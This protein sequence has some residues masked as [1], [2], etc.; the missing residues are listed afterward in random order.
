MNE[1]ASR[2]ERLDRLDREI[3]R[4]THELAKLAARAEERRA[5]VR[6]AQARQL[7]ATTAL[8]TNRAAERAAARKIEEFRGSR[9]AAMR[10]LTTGVGNAEAAQRQLERCDTLIDESETAMLELLE[11][12]DALTA[13]K[14]AADAALN[15]AQVAL[16][17]EERVQPEQIAH[18][19][20]ARAHSTLE[21]AEA[22][23]DLP[24]D[25]RNRYE[26]FRERG[27]FAVARVRDGSCD[28]CSMAVQA[29]M[30]AD[31]KRDKL[32]ACHGCHRWLIL[33]VP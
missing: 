23:A 17:E 26:S 6:E 30:V 27:R 15:S 12:Q 8:D 4:A 1:D 13:D 29:Q 21:R 19:E 10:V 16:T 32:V 7:A 28:T 18:L 9:E 22:A 14:Q 11:Q 24:S 20:Q 2:L 33:A 31:L 25:L 3:A 5:A